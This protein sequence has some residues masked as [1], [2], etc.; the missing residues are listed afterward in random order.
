M[1]ARTRPRAEQGRRQMGRGSLRE[2]LRERRVLRQQLR[3]RLGRGDHGDSRRRGWGHAD[4]RRMTATLTPTAARIAERRNPHCFSTPIAESRLTP[5]R[6]SSIVRP[7]IR[8]TDGGRGSGESV[9]AGVVVLLCLALG[10]ATPRERVCAEMCLS[11]GA[12]PTTKFLA[13]SSGQRSWPGLTVDSTRSVATSVPT[14]SPGA[15]TPPRSSS[16]VPTSNPTCIERP[17]DGR[18]H[19]ASPPRPLPSP[20]STDSTRCRPRSAKRERSGLAPTLVGNLP[21]RADLRVSPPT[22]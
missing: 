9:R 7:T 17:L 20:G 12:A 18:L 21:Q 1:R 4:G 13:D 22:H 8:P 6:S 2:D 3:R 19:R 11:C 16:D 15:H 10:R 14:Q 5:A